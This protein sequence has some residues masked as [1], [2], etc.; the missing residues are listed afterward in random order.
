[1]R[2]SRGNSQAK[3]LSISS[4]TGQGETNRKLFYRSSY[5]YWHHARCY[6]RRYLAQKIQSITGELDSGIPS[7]DEA[8][9]AVSG[10]QDRALP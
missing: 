7:Q 5:L 2:G 6:S 9:L 10:E 3:D 1:M 8:A 4:T